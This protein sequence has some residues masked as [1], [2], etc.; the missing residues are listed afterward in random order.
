MTCVA[1]ASTS[2][3]ACPANPTVQSTKTPPRD[4]SRCSSTSATMTGSC[5]GT[6]SFTFPASHFS[7]R[8]QV[9]W[10]YSRAERE[11]RTATAEP[12]VNTNRALENAEARTTV[13]RRESP[14]QLSDAVIRETH[15]VFVGPRFA[16]QLLEEPLIVPDLQVLDAAK[17]TDV[18][19]NRRALAKM[20]RNHDATLAI[21]LARLTVVIHP[22]EKLETRRMVS[23]HFHQPPLDVEPHRHRID[24]NRLSR[25][26]RDKDVGPL[27]VLG[28]P[29]KHPRYLESAFFINLGRGA[30]AHSV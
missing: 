30:P 5:P 25:E 22:V 9:R 27:F 20:S 23:G 16:L 11:R 8:V 6:L 21:E 15:A 13:S 2:A 7:V 19:D 12:N 18:A 3:R 26:A 17:H 1:P 14:S 10:C 4:G 28:V 24:A 29:S